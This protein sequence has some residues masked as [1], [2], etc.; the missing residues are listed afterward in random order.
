MFHNNPGRGLVRFLGRRG[1]SF[2]ETSQLLS[3]RAEFQ[4]QAFKDFTQ[5]PLQSNLQCQYFIGIIPFHTASS[6]RHDE[7][8]F[9]MK[10]MT[11]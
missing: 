4:T 2:R 11:K 3:G 5:W 9:N 10:G 6:R 1:H 7:N 8:N